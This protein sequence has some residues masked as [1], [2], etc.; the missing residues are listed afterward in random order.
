MEQGAA[1]ATLLAPLADVATA[2]VVDKSHNHHVSSTIL[3]LHHASARVQL[4]LPLP[5]PLLMLLQLLLQLLPV[6]HN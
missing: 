1:V 5:L 4:L 6:V 2:S 3:G